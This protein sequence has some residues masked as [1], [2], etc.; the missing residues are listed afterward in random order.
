M[1][2]ARNHRVSLGASII[3]KAWAWFQ[4]HRLRA[5][6]RLPDVSANF[7]MWMVHHNVKTWIIGQRAMSLGFPLSVRSR[8]FRF[9]FCLGRGKVLCFCYV[10]L[11]LFGEGN[12]DCI[13]YC[14]IIQIF[15]VIHF[16]PGIQAPFCEQR[17]FIAIQERPKR[18]DKNFSS[19]M[20]GRHEAYSFNDE[21]FLITR[22]QGLN[23]YPGTYTTLWSDKHKPRI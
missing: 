23:N 1:D 2:D 5:T 10:F 13:A 9:F 8:N 16:L 12:L 7:N 20:L 14:L 21:N 17:E 11:P 18:T 22:R 4:E 19:T 6:A 15:T 3:W